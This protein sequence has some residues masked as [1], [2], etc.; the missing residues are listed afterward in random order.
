MAFE[1]QISKIDPFNKPTIKPL[2]VPNFENRLKLICKQILQYSHMYPLN[3]N[4][5][6]FVKNQLNK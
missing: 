1:V 3:P 5:E 6:S 2:E 4:L